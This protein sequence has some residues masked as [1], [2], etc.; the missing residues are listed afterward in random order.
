VNGLGTNVLVRYLTRDDA[1]QARRAARYIES[2]VSYINC[3]VLCEL[4]WVLESA[5]GYPRT[6]VAEV[7]GKVL[8]TSEFQIE[9]RDLAGLALNDYRHT[10]ADFAD[11]LIVR[12]N[13]AARCKETATFDKK[14]KAIRGSRLL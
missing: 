14:L 7:L 2:G 5:Y 3:I 9:D 4:V 13:E 11:C 6:T 1:E 8:M 10:T 12:R